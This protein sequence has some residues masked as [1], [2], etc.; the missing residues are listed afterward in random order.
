MRAPATPSSSARQAAA[1]IARALLRTL[2]SQTVPLPLT[3][4]PV[5][6]SPRSV[7]FPRAMTARRTARAE[8][9]AGRMRALAWTSRAGAG[10]T[11]PLASA[12]TPAQCSQSVTAPAACRARLL[13]R[14]R[15]RL[16]STNHHAA[17]SFRR[18]LGGGGGGGRARRECRARRRSGS[19]HSSRSS[20]VSRTWPCCAHQ[21]R[22]RLLLH[23]R[24]R[25]ELRAG[26][27]L[28][29]RFG[30][31]SRRRTDHVTADG[32]TLMGLFDGMYQD[33][34]TG[35]SV[36]VRL[37]RPPDRSGRTR[38]VGQR[39][40]HEPDRSEHHLRRH[41]ERQRRFDERHL[42]RDKDGKWTDV[43]TRDESDRPAP[44]RSTCTASCAS[45]RAP[46]AA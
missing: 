24:R 7:T 25:Q 12:G 27:H 31:D 9:S 18:C 34:G 44:R 37:R 17:R 32:K 5:D 38:Q 23:A 14:C 20:R 45:T 11:C 40:R 3:R 42:P 2:A 33:D 1:A 8:P 36:S 29:D 16:Y 26:V 43:G 22:R 39:L 19:S 15:R 6:V 13:R 41:L 35:C 46:R 21:R 4:P 28:G 30:I 10:R